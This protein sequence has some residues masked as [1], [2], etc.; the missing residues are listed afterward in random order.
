ML[1]EFKVTVI[2][3]NRDCMAG[4]YC[5]IGVQGHRYLSNPGGFV[6]KELKVAVISAILEDLCLKNSKSLL[7]QQSWRICVKRIKSRRYLSNP[8][9]FVLK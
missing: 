4:G 6:L 3:A 2:S 7:S 9:G 8:G 5:R 1:K